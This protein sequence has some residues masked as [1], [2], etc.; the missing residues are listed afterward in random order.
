VFVSTEKATEKKQ[1]LMDELLLEDADFSTQATPTAEPQGSQR[2]AHH[3]ILQ[4]PGIQRSQVHLSPHRLT[5]PQQQT[6]IIDQG[7]GEGWC[8]E[9]QCNAAEW[10]GEQGCA[11][12]VYRAQRAPVGWRN[13]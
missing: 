5:T 2:T 1:L 4:L 8:V 10:D 3:I 12:L 11:W 7:V 6:T 13:E 9:F